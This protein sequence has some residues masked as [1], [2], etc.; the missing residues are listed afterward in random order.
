MCNLG[1]Y[2]NLFRVFKKEFG[3]TPKEYY[4]EI[5]KYK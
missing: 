1:S 2:N 5:K 3:I 4:N